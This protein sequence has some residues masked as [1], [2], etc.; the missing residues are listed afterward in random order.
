MSPWRRLITPLV[1]TKVETVSR[2][3]L[4][5]VKTNHWRVYVFGILIASIWSDPRP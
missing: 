3:P 2:G 1:V 5:T 4:Y